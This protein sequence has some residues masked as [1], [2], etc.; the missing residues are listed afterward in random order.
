MPSSRRSSSCW[1]AAA[2]LEQHQNCAVEPPENLERSW[3]LAARKPRRAAPQQKFEPPR[4]VSAAAFQPLHRESDRSSARQ[5][6]RQQRHRARGRKYTISQAKV[7][8]VV[9]VEHE[10]YLSLT[11]GW[12]TAPVLID[13]VPLGSTLGVNS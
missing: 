10:C 9:D 11:S 4:G 1:G 13:K 7:I 5:G 6:R 12:T 3:R 8:S 2:S